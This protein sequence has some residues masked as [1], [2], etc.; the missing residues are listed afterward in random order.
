VYTTAGICSRK[1]GGCG[2]DL[3]IKTRAPKQFCPFNKC[4]S[5]DLTEYS[6][7]Y[8]KGKV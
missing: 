2:C 5:V 6:N 1:K 3:G 8:Y 4:V 7:E